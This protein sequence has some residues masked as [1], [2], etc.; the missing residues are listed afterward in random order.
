MYL[1]HWPLR[2][3]SDGFPWIMV[4]RGSF[5]WVMIPLLTYAF[6]NAFEAQSRTLDTGKRKLD[7]DSNTN[8]FDRYSNL[9]LAQMCSKITRV[10]VRSANSRLSP[11]C[12][13]ISNVPNIRDCSTLNQTASVEGLCVN[14]IMN[15]QGCTQLDNT[16]TDQRKRTRGNTQTQSAISLPSSKRT[17]RSDSLA[18]NRRRQTVTRPN[19]E[20][21]SSNPNGAYDDLGDYDQRCLHCGAAFWYEERIKSHSVNHKP[22]YH[23]CCGGGKIYMQP[24]RDPP[25]YVK[26]L[27]QNKHFMENIRAYNQMFAMTSFGAKIDESINAGRGLYVF[28]VSGQVYHWIGSLFPPV[29]EAPRF[30][31]L[32][33]YD[34]DNE[35][36][37]RMRHF[38]GLENSSLDPEIVHGLIY[39]LDAHNELVQLSRIARDK[40][41]E[42]DVPEFKI[43][44]LTGTTYFDVVIQHR[45]GPSQRVNKVHPSYM[46]SQFPLL[47]I[48]GQSVFHTEL[49]LQSAD[50][51]GKAKRVTMLVYYQYQLHHRHNSYNLTFKGGRLFQQYV[52]GVFCCIEQ[53]RLDFIRKKQSDISGD[54]LSGLYDA[55][56]RGERDGYEVGG[57]IILPMSFTGGPRYMYTHYLDA[58]AICRKLGNPQFFITFTC[59]VNWPEIKRGTIQNKVDRETY[60]ANEFDQFIAEPGEALVSVY[61]RFAQLMNDLERNDMH[62]PIVTINTKF[63]HSLQPEWLKY[64]FENLVN[65]SRV[66]KVKKSHDP[67]ALV[68]HTGSC[69]RNTSSYYVTHPTYVVDYD[70][71]YQQDDIQ[72][73]Y[74]DPLTST[75]LLLA[76]AITQNFSNPTNN[77]LHTSSNTINQAVIQG[78]R[79]N[80]Q[81]RNSG[82]AGR[83]N[84]RAYVQEEVV[85]GSNE[86]RNVQRTLRNSS[87]RNNSTVQCY[88]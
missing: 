40:C 75:M 20:G 34:T 54:Y 69:S 84:R 33:I 59:N 68:A 46:S 49:K 6:S 12:P 73:N 16:G 15:T 18:T 53:N 76:R 83:N 44:G 74:E 10:C 50:G 7:L 48:Y 1:H 3:L 8:P 5:L 72:T 47:F 14:D 87:S 19:G 58:L 81:S 57:R 88:N 38:G 45:D 35:V 85:E 79:V 13:N 86:T 65:T 55:I 63:L 60:F 25:E 26:H 52:V 64:Q 24:E 36:E 51:S 77:R 56:S 82:N 28:K 39:F 61:N 11:D 41:R 71:E 22:K 4:Q 2:V 31:Q 27:F 32:Y 30:L 67:L 17:R 29:G 42:I 62:F 21:S 43:S 9:V 66:K 37:N 80:I 70:D 78:D 23:L